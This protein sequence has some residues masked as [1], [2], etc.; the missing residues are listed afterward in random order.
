M[1]SNNSD[2]DFGGL[3]RKRRKLTKLTLCGHNA[4]INPLLK[5][6]CQSLS[7]QGKLLRPNK[8]GGLEDLN[9]SLPLGH[10]FQ[11]SPLLSL[12]VVSNKNY[13]IVRHKSSPLL[14]G[15][16]IPTSTRIKESL[17]LQRKLL[18]RQ[19][20][21][22]NLSQ[23]HHQSKLTRSQCANNVEAVRPKI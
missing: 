7:V 23:L 13:K 12:T 1:F 18:D 15:L 8:T 9:V 4:T 20:W 2:K 5:V 21:H 10:T 14:G 19:E 22:Y 3:S 17:F 16:L 6:S 11:S